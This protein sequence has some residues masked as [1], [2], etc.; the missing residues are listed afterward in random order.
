M[1]FAEFG[2]RIN[3]AQLSCG[4]EAG[5]LHLVSALM[6]DVYDYTVEALEEDINCLVKLE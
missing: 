1:A 5:P 3:A 6:K 4:A 2:D